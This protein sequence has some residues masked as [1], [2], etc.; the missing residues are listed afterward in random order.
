MFNLGRYKD[1]DNVSTDQDVVSVDDILPD[2]SS[3]HKIV[4]NN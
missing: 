2:D 3:V 1:Q 4:R